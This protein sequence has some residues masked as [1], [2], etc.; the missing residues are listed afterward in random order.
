MSTKLN[1]LLFNMRL[2]SKQ[3]IRASKKAEKRSKDAKIKIKK[4]IET[5]N[6]EGAR[7]Y[8]ENAIREHNCAQTFMKYSSRI[9]GL[10][11]RLSMQTGMMAMVSTLS[12]ITKGLSSAMD[13]MDMKKINQVMAQF[14]QQ[15]DHMDVTSE[16]VM[17][18]MDATTD[19]QIES[20]DVSQ[21]ISQVAAEHQLSLDGEF[22][23]FKADTAPVSE[24]TSSA[25]PA[26]DVDD[27]DARLQRLLSGGS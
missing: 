26:A 23:R 11:S 3:F 9:D 6:A 18:Q 22:E 13:S 24:A 1:D 5:N 4:A 21:L 19:E 8:A 20:A 16:V 14:Q 27:V 12:G 25:A 17:K 10:C 15:M 7:I 2:T